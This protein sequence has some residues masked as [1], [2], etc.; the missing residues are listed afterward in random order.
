MTANHLHMQRRRTEKADGR[1]LVYY[2]F[3]D[4]AEAAGGRASSRE[5]K[6]R[7]DPGEAPAPQMRWNP[8]LQQWIVV[9][10]HRQERTFLPA[11]E[12]CPLCPTRDPGFPTEIPESDFDV[13]AFEN[14]FPS[15]VDA[16]EPIA[17]VEDDLYSS[18]PA[19][20]RC[21]VVVYTPEHSS[22]LA[23]QSVR[24]VRKVVEVWAD[25]YRELGALEDVK[26]VFVFENRGEEVGVTLH[27][28]HCQIYA[29]PFVPPVVERELASSRAHWERK[30]E[31]L[32]CR[33]LAREAAEGSRMV[34][35]SRA[36]VAFVPFY[37]RWPYEVHVFPKRHTPSLAEM[38]GPERE[39]LA[40]AVKTVAMK[41]DGLFGFPLPYVMVMH[42][43]PTDGGDHG[44]YHF[45]IEFYPPY[46]TRDR[47]KYLAGVELG[48]GLFLNDAQPEEKA[49]ELRELKPDGE[50]GDG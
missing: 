44:H 18:R 28:P 33:I 39:D 10:A 3:D 1:Y 16:A 22:S 47:L 2:R 24:Q 4:E 7:R 45:H 5:E 25:R 21:E 17:E 20:G 15:F 26:Y 36:H 42:Q 23:Q 40:R 37:A 29:L 30:G 27:H 19:R 31:C 35:E 6:A 49:R 14:R 38:G 34:F 46:R 50:D 12:S 11:E 43:R 48:A 8:V 9:A 32:F 41:Y 13:V